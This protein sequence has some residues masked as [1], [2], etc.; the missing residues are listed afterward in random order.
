[1]SSSTWLNQLVP[2]NCIQIPFYVFLLVLFTLPYQCCLFSSNPINNAF[3]MI[4]VTLLVMCRNHSFSGDTPEHATRFIALAKVGNM[5]KHKWLYAFSLMPIDQ[6][7][8]SDLYQETTDQTDCPYMGT[9]LQPS[10]S[11][12][13]VNSTLPLYIWFTL[14]SGNW[15]NSACFL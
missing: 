10:L 14:Q 6:M 12:K 15:T 9:M 7:K 11:N 8:T 4:E 5:L 2:L 1:M 13:Q 3:R